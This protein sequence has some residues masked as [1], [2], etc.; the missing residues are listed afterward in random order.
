[1]VLIQNAIIDNA[2]I[3]I[4]GHGILSSMVY[5][6]YGEGDCQGFGGYSLEKHALSSWVRNMFRVCDVDKWSDLAGRSIRVE[7]DA[8]YGKIIKVGHYLKD[9]WFDPSS[10]L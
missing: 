1:M 8:P 7:L 10:D 3:E 9:E 5:L 2:T 4:E 6:G